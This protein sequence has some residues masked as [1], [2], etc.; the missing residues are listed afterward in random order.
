LRDSCSGLSGARSGVLTGL[1]RFESTK[2]YDLA[3]AL[4]LFLF[5][6]WTVWRNWPALEERML[7]LRYGYVDAKVAA[8][9]VAL[10]LSVLFS[11]LLLVLL[12]VRRVPA[13]KTRGLL[14]R[15]V[16]AAGTF[17]AIAFLALPGAPLPEALS[18]ISAG[19]IILGTLATIVALIWLGRSFSI[20]P[21][22]RRLVTTGP[23]ALVR[24]PVYLFEEITIFGIML[25]HAQP[26][27]FVLFAW[28]FG[29]QLLRIHYEER[30]LTQVFPEYRAYAARKARLIPGIY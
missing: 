11:A 23:Y 1:R 3:A 28:Q 10:V 16:A 8:D 26:W 4:P 9:A 12:L 5:Y 6:G 30:I 13:G 25:Q 24:H 27:S 15:A 2:A 14:P 21:E 19:L 18:M 17:L 22:A 20:M 7:I 29:L